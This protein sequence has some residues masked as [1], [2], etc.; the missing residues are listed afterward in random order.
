MLM[1]TII[2][3]QMRNVTNAT[4]FSSEAENK[5]DVASVEKFIVAISAELPINAGS[6]KKG[7]MDYIKNTAE[8]QDVVVVAS[9]FAAKNLVS[10]TVDVS[11][12]AEKS[13]PIRVSFER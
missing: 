6:N 2:H 3:E 5:I 8:T 9:L 13:I 10:V 11:D 7:R 12:I 1:A 4:T